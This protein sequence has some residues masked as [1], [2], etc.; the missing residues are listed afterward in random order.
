MA[1]IGAVVQHFVRFPGFEEVKGGTFG[2]IY[3]PQGTLG[4]F[5]VLVGCAF[6]E[7][8]WGEDQESRWAGDYGNPWRVPLLNDVMRNK[9]LNNGRM[10]MISVLG[11]WMAEMTSGKDAIEQFGL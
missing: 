11:I 4:L 3:D 7:M 9:E 1:S 2:A 10:A 5:F 6:H 8:F